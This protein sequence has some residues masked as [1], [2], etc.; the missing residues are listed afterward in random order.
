MALRFTPEEKSFGQG[1]RAFVR[2]TLPEEI[3][4]KV[5]NGSLLTRDELMRWHRILAEHGWG[6]PTWP[7]EHGGTGW[8]PVQEFIF[9]EEGAAWGAPRLLPLG[10]RMVGPVI[11]TLGNAP[12][13]PPF[14]PPTPSPPHLPPP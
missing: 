3:R 1:V 13:Q 12:P 7:K 4:H 5:Q 9:E 11:I 10:L 14:L 6:A 2:A 8:D